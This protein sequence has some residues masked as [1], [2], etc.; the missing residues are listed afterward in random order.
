MLLA[1]RYLA[2]CFLA[3]CSM[4]S[5]SMLHALLLHANR[6]ARSD[7]VREGSFGLAEIQEAGEEENS[8]QKNGDQKAGP[9]QWIR[10]RGAPSGIRRLRR[11]SD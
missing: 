10:R 11:P 4:L 3:P 1:P 7:D 2:P 8:G 9:I 6:A 5:C